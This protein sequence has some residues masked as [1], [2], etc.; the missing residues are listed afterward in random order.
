MYQLVSG[1][2]RH[3]LFLHLK[4][5]GKAPKDQAKL[6]HNHNIPAHLGKLSGRSSRTVDKTVYIGN[7][8]LW[9]TGLIFLLLAR[10]AYFAEEDHIG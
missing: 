10:V 8:L 6:N 7:P 2:S 1:V 9:L 4:L 3:R 5:S